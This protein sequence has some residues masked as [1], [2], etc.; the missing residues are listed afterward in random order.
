MAI[1]TTVAYAFGAHTVSTTVL[2]LVD[3]TGLTAALVGRA[4]RVRLTCNSGALHY[5]YDGGDPTTASGHYLGV[6]AST[7]IVGA[8][9]IEQLRLS[10]SGSTDAALAVTLEA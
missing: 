9:N 2:G 5:R 7:E 1:H 3:V 4:A 6:N 10:R 8:Q